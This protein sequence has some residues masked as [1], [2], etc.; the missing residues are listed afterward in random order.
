M[1]AGGGGGAG[2]TILIDVRHYQLNCP[3]NIQSHGGNGG[4][5]NTGSIHGGGGGGGVGALLFNMAPLTEVG[6]MAT[7]GNAG[8]DCNLSGSSCNPTGQ[9]G[10]AGFNPVII[11]WVVSGLAAPLPIELQSFQAVPKEAQVHIWWVTATEQNSD[12][13]EI[14]RSADLRNIELIHQTPAFGNSPTPRHY[15]F[16]DER[17]L[18]GV[19]YYR[20]KSVDRDQIIQYSSWVSV[21][22]YESQGFALYPNPSQGALYVVPQAKIATKMHIQLMNGQGILLKEWQA[23]AST[24]LNLE[25]Y[26]PGIYLL[27]IINQGEVFEKKI[28]RQ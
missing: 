26:P 4:N 21:Q 3:L 16:S 25:N 14:E 13:F 23:N 22:R 12:Y 11:G 27:R 6:I 18:A 7:H 9:A 17:P 8:R 10:E 1:D 19:S 5:V 15:S 28:V 20:L 2:G 24:I